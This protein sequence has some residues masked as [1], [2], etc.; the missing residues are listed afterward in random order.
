KTDGAGADPRAAR[1]PDLGQRL[2]AHLVRRS[3]GLGRALCAATGLG[4]R[5]GDLQE[6]PGR[7]S[8]EVVRLLAFFAR[9][10]RI[11]LPLAP[12]ARVQL[13]AAQ[14]GELHRQQVVTRGN[15]RAAVVD[16]LA[17]RTIAE[18]TLE[19]RFQL[20]GAFEAALVAHVVHVEAVERARNAAGDRVDRLL[21]RAVARRRAR[22]E[23]QAAARILRERG[24]L[25]R[26]GGADLDAVL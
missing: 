25:H 14:A 5:R 1:S 17:R 16:H 2:S 7:Q 12:R 22:I 6:N 8:R 15:A 10:L 11:G 3:G 19:V 18:H 13:A 21:L 24:D 26:H 4:T 20:F 9:P 23:Q